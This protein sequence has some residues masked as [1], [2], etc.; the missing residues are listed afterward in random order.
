ME[1]NNITKFRMVLLTE[2]ATKLI[3]DFG[4]EPKVDI[5]LHARFHADMI[6]V[7]AIQEVYGENLGTLETRHPAT[8]LQMLKEQYVPFWLLRRWPVRYETQ[9]YDARVLYPKMSFPGE[10][11]HHTWTRGYT[12]E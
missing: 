10:I 6:S 4:L 8:W 11:H 7:R 3:E 5:S 12:D 1:E 2:L 9:M